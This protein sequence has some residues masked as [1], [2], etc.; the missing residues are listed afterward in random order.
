M[1]PLD[2][3]EIGSRTR[4]KLTSDSVARARTNRSY[5]LGWGASPT[6]APCSSRGTVFMAGEW[7][8][9]WRSAQ[10]HGDSRRRNGL[11]EVVALV[12]EHDEGGEI[13]HIDFPDRLHAQLGVLEDL[14]LGD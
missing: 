13:A 5:G 10:R 7:P 14:G 11:E 9:P 12:V 6:Q 4:T 3:S 2:V 8:S 1:T